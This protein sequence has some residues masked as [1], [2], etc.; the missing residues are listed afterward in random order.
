MQKKSG[1][2]QSFWTS[3]LLTVNNSNPTCGTMS[4][5]FVLNALAK[6]PVAII[7]FF[8]TCKH[9]FCMLN[10]RNEAMNEAMNEQWRHEDNIMTHPRNDWFFIHYCIQCKH[11][12]SCAPVYK[13]FVKCISHKPRCC[14]SATPSYFF[15]SPFMLPNPL[16]SRFKH[17]S[18]TAVS[19][20]ALGPLTLTHDSRSTSQTSYLQRKRY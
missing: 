6:R 19:G 18:F 10:M 9:V 14:L 12:S 1:P 2:S 7:S 5:I 8:V 15:N 17:P 16:E 13:F 20:S 3:I 11:S 4:C